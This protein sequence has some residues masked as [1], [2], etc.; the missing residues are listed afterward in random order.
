MSAHDI[1]VTTLLNAEEFISLEAMVDE[2]GLSQSALIRTLLHKAFR[3]W[4]LT[5]VS[6]QSRL[7]GSVES[8]Q[9]V[10]K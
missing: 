10:N 1:R 8:A 2:M 9:V 3:E 4:A 6:E 7:A 5:K